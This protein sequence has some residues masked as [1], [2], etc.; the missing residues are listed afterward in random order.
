MHIID[1]YPFQLPPSLEATEV[2]IER[3]KSF[4]RAV[5]LGSRMAVEFCHE[6]WFNDE[7]VD[8]CREAPAKIVSVDSP[9]GT[10]IE[11]GNG[12]VYIGMYGR[13]AWYAHDYSRGKLKEGP[14]RCLASSRGECMCSSI[15]ITGCSRMLWRS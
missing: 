2:N 11:S 8:M 14:R 5:R 1:F 9:V 12:I 3:I 4:A 6:S 13:T 15:T 10:W 7:T